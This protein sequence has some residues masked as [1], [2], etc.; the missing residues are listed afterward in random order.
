MEQVNTAFVFLTL[1][2]IGKNLFFVLPV[3]NMVFYVRMVT[4]TFRMN[5]EYE[6]ILN[7]EASKHGLT[8]S[9]LLNHIIRQYILVTR[10]CE[11]TPVITLSYNTFAPILKLIDDKELIEEAE[12]TGGI[13][14]E[15]A[16]LQRGKRLD[17]DTI[18]WF[19][20]VVYGRYSNWFDV[21]HSTVNN[22]ERLHL[23]HQ[24]NH[25]WSTYLS[26]YMNGMFKSILDIEPKTETRA[27]SVTIYLPRSS[28]NRLVKESK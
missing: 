28:H 8:V 13:L 1:Q 3:Y 24:M 12:K 18:T 16:M 11:K 26:G 6:K 20:E 23:A 17:F 27:N 9:A 10:F 14:P 21:T 19:I 2:T 25:K 22:K 15:E 7:E 4:R 5:P